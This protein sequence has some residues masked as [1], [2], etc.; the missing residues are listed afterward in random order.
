MSP[1]VALRLYEWF[2]LRYAKRHFWR[3][4]AVILGLSLGAGVFVAVRLAVTTSV[5]SFEQ[6]MEA[7][8]GSADFVVTRPGG[9]VP[10]SVVRDLLALPVVKTASPLM[11]V[12]VKA[13]VSEGGEGTAVRLVGLD[14]ILDRPLRS[15]AIRPTSDGTDTRKWTALMAERDT[16]FVG[17]AVARRLGLEAGSH[18][19]VRYQDRLRALRVLGVLKDEGL[20]LADGGMVVLADLATAQEF[21]GFLDGV[22]RVEVAFRPGALEPGFGALQSLLG[23]EYAVHRLEERKRS[24]RS[25]VAA[26]EQNLSV[27]SFVSLFVGM[28]LVYS[29]TAFNS[30]SRRREV[31]VLRS[32]GASSR[33]VFS[34]FLMDGVLLGLLGWAVGIPV[35][36]LF[37]KDL[38]RAVSGTVTLL[39]ARVDVEGLSLSPWDVGGSIGLTAGVAALAALQ[40][41]RSLMDV[42]P[43]EAIRPRSTGLGS[44]PARPAF[45]QMDA[46]KDDG[47]WPDPKSPSVRWKRFLKK[48]RK[49]FSGPGRLTGLGLALLGLVWP[50]ALAPP[51][52]GIPA[53]GYASVFFLFCGFSLLAPGALKK[54]SGLSP[55][56]VR[57]AAGEPCVLALRNLDMAGSRIAVSIGALV[58]AVAL[59]TALAVMIASFRKTV[60]VWVHQTVSGDLFLRPM[61]ADLNG[62]RDPLPND[63]VEF[64]VAVPDADV[65][66]YRRIAINYA[67]VECS[68][69]GIDLERLR[70]H[71][72]FL[73]RKG[74]AEEAYR[75]MASGDGVI[76]SEVLSNRTG[77]GLG[78]R[79]RTVVH[80]RPMDFA[81][82]G[83]YRDYRT[84]GAVV[85]MDAQV[86][87]R[88]TGDL[89]W[90][91]AR[92]FFSGS[93]DEVA[94]K[95]QRLQDEIL[96][97]FGGR[98]E[99]DM[100][101][102]RELRRDILDVFDQTF[103]VTT[104]LLLMAL[105]VAGLGMMTTL[106]VMVL[107]RMVPL[108]TLKA[109]G[110]SSGQIRR[111]LLWEAAFMTA[112][113]S[114]LGLGCGFIL[115]VILIDVINAQSFG[116]TFLYHIPWSQ[117]GVALPLIA[118]ASLGATVP[119]QRLAF[120]HSPAI[121]LRE[122]A[123]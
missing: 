29:L 21:L 112:V 82:V 87:H 91:G 30:V 17:S 46:G 26:Y 56:G 31:A 23:T 122:D 121:L 33:L 116:W 64:L 92:V 10:L 106:T 44:F 72:G 42:P 8:T 84:Q 88:R 85:Y 98:Y 110:A 108:N 36:A 65:V 45:Q 114:L 90:S 5:R 32:L 1:A 16:V 83:I 6:S 75:A 117:L 66:S 102:G 11:T 67:G 103:A 24:G 27:L 105:L 52:H 55:H 89:S 100:I 58:T 22:D 47:S 123:R 15:W 9:S 76:V 99:L 77:L 4:A 93:E 3:T 74:H 50:L 41:A 2:S 51:V 13:H 71:G 20:G 68:L 60:E 119:A 115:S 120:R 19:T 104:V 107:E 48:L 79:F 80:G 53:A 78:D 63:V 95:V 81:V 94:E 61:M 12:T 38:L 35:S 109:V 118:A 111:M 69:E 39:F 28:F 86:L 7:V 101:M 59:F 54:V 14:P 49:G 73:F 40:P 25:M 113:G 96:T 70:R 18:L 34:L 57:K 37:A 97:R 43:T 62:Y